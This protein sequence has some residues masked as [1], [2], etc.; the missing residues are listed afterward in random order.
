MILNISGRTDIVAFYSKWFINRY[1]AGFVDVR[2][3]FYPKQISRI[4][5][6]DV[7]AILF[8]TKNPLPI[9]KYLTQ[10][11]KPMLFHVTITPYKRDIEPNVPPKGR[12]IEAIKKLSKIIGKKNL[13]VRYDPIFLN[14]KYTLA[15]HKKAFN[16]LCTLLNGYVDKIIVSFIDE[17]KN[18]RKNIN[19]L[20]IEPFT[21]EDYQEIGLSFSQS[22]KKNGMTVQTCF[23]EQKLTEYGFVKRECL[24]KE[25][26]HTLTGKTKFQKWKARTGNKCECVK[27]VDIGE[28]NSCCHFCKYCYANYDETKV[29]QNFRN[30]NEH[31]S[32]LVGKIEKDDIIKVRMQ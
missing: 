17:Y 29:K 22:A 9:L 2:N 16:H 7:Q 23:E 12:I 14:D 1:K 18:V 21:K 6:K 15:Y 26:A 8:C 24:S 11:D 27:M 32:L 3:P 13:Y 4:Y 5:F 30:H 19:V 31:S 10:I 28:Y 20:K 25:L